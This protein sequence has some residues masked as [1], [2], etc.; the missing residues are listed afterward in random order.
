VT[1]APAPDHV[2]LSTDDLRAVARYAADCAAQVL[3]GFEAVVPDDP[4]PRE[5]LAAA[6]AFADGAARSNRQRTAA[7]AAHRAASA[8]DDEIAR[9]GALACGDAAAAAYLHPI[10][11][12]TQVG[13]ILRAAACVARVAEL[14]AVAGHAHGPAAA[15]E[16]VAALARLA[17]P[18]V[19]AVLRRYPP[20][21]AGRHRLA[22][23]TSALDTA[24]R[25]RD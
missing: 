9:L 14:R 15:D 6:R 4:R 10:A 24:V 7:V 16:A 1:A 13:H 18:P 2:E 17:A 12:S 3:A 21:P 8:V 23:L 22:E 25:A 20:A 5:A 11:R 19:P